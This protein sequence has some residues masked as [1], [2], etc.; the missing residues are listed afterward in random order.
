MNT[1]SREEQQDEKLVRIDHLGS[2]KRWLATQA[3]ASQAPASEV[4]PASSGEPREE[5]SHALAS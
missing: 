2:A 3:R 1:E 4:T 5:R